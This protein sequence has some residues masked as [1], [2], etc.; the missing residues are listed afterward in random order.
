MVVGA[1]PSDSRLCVQVLTHLSQLW[2]PGSVYCQ[3]GTPARAFWVP[4][5]CLPDASSSTKKDLNI[6]Y[7]DDDLMS[8]FLLVWP[9][10]PDLP[11]YTKKIPRFT[12]L[13]KKITL[14]FLLKIFSS[15]Q[16]ASSS[17][18]NILGS[19]VPRG[20]PAQSFTEGSGESLAAGSGRPSASRR[21][22]G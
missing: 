18:I 2:G 8:P 17:N 11:V 6:S 14:F 1:G 15:F 10:S 13:H 19:E 22:L 7:V 3:M 12:S 20:L 4:G 21:E 5:P 16:N 9:F